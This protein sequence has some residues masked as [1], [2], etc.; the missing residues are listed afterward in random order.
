MSQQEHRNT[1]WALLD[2]AELRVHRHASV[3][4]AHPCLQRIWVRM[5]D[6]LIEQQQAHCRD[7]SDDGKRFNCIQIRPHANRVEVDD[8]LDGRHFAGEADWLKEVA[9]ETKRRN[10]GSG[11][12]ESKI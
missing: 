3:D 4:D 5:A 6:L 9:R 12:N 7:L 1:V 10:P 2:F 11:R 8:G